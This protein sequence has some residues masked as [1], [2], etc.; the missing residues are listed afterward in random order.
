MTTS[1]ISSSRY[2]YN[3]L[4]DM[5]TKSPYLS[6]QLFQ[7][8]GIGNREDFRVMHEYRSPREVNENTL[9]CID[10]DDDDTIVLPVKLID[11]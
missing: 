11:G 5:M 4:Y 6:W 2:S 3:Q 10:F 1:T 8:F 7:Y 9:S